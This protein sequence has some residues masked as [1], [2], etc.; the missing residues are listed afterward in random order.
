MAA[1]FGDY[2]VAR[3]SGFFD[4]EYYLATYPDVAERNI[5]PLVHYLEEGSLEGRNPHADFDS[6]FYLEQCKERGEE[7]E[8]PLL[9]YIRIGAARGFKTRREGAGLA[10]PARAAL[11]PQGATAKMPILVAVETLGVAGVS[12][13]GSRLSI[14]GWALAAAPI[15]EISAALDGNL[16]GKANY[17]LPRPDIALLYPARAEAGLSGFMLTVELPRVAGE[18]LEPV[19]TVRTAD[20]EIGRRALRVDVPPQEVEVPTID[21]SAPAAAEL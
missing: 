5:D 3:K 21:P 14:A 19:L 7:P 6:A 8:N 16:L 9:H 12:A 17:G 15:V 18:T 2:E 1:L 11:D 13:G 10:P 20:G 4:P